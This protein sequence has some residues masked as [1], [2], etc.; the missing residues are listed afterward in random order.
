M[1]AWKPTFEPDSIYDVKAYERWRLWHVYQ[2]TLTGRKPLPMPKGESMLYAAGNS[3]RIKRAWLQLL[4]RLN[5][6]KRSTK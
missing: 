5:P 1:R 6:F 3:Y 2:Q 4:S